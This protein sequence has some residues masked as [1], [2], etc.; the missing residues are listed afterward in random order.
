MVGQPRAT[1]AAMASYR[2]GRS[3]AQAADE[4]GLDETVKLASNENP[5][6]PVTSIVE[7]V[8]AA[9]GSVSTDSFRGGQQAAK[10]ETT[11]KPNSV[12]WA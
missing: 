2:P 3:A 1:V 7:A 12:R 9:A 6:L 5:S 4:H 8:A 10:H 11:S